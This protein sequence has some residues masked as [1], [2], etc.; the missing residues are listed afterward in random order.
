[1]NRGT[2]KVS[3]LHFYDVTQGNIHLKLDGVTVIIRT[4]FI[5]FLVHYEATYQWIKSSVGELADMV[6]LSSIPAV[7]SVYLV[8]VEMGEQ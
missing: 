7:G 6:I 1:M 3:A 8:S 2:T 4:M 5:N